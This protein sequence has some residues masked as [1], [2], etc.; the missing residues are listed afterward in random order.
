MPLVYHGTA[1]L[2]GDWER[3]FA[4]RTVRV[5]VT[6]LE[7][8]VEELGL[9][10]IDWLLVDVEGYELEVL[11]GGLSALGRVQRAIVEVSLGNLGRCR[12]CSSSAG[13]RLA[14]RGSP[15]ESVQY[16]LFARPAAQTL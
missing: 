11:R 9:E 15:E 3:R 8:L 5:R 16:H 13:L 12:R 1:S 2:R 4:T 10:R 14:E 6:T 7:R